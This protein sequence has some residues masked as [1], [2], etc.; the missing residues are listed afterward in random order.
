MF[1]SDGQTDMTKLTVS[2]CKH[3]K[4][5]QNEMKTFSLSTVQKKITPSYGTKERYFPFR[6]RIRY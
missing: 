2:F 1:Y 4:S 3:L 5:G 6:D